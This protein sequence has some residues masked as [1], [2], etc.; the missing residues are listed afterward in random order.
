M[1]AVAVHAVVEGADDAP[2]LVLSPS[3]G[4]TLE[5][6]DRQVPTLLERFRVIRYDPRGH[7]RSPVPAGPYE[8]ADL[9]ADV[10]ALLD[11]LDVETAHF[12]GLS[13]GGMTGLALAVEHPAWLD[14]L[15]LAC[16]TA[17]TG[18]AEV[19]RERA[20]TVSRE[21]VEAIADTV[22]GRWLTP[23]YAEAHPDLVHRLRAMLVATSRQG[24]AA[25]CGA[26]ERMDLRET[27][28]GITLPTLVISALEDPSIPPEHQRR[29][30]EG[31]PGSRLETL[32]PAAHLANL[33]QPAA[34]SRMLMEHF[35]GI[36]GT[37]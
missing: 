21:G 3:L 8:I 32:S 2:A 25:C 34:F 4:S 15:A 18:S 17:Y 7:G 29:L 31:I 30:A 28:P 27:L 35:T 9:S 37:S 1:T 24:Y 20:E 26:I 33:E 14:R 6:W 23:A 22:V 19:W 12:C 10:V 11:R 36:Q 16:T 13:L 5:M